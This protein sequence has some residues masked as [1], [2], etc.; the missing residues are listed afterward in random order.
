MI[1]TKKLKQDM[2]PATFSEA[3]INVQPR[4]S[5]RYLMYLKNQYQE[6]MTGLTLA[7]IEYLQTQGR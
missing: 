7:M 3:E 4:A 5:D 1:K 2:K 6:N